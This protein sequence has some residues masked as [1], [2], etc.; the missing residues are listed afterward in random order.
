MHGKLSYADAFA[1]SLAIEKKATIG[2]GD[3]EFSFLEQ[4]VDIFWLR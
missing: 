3:H 1:A 2:T 4:R